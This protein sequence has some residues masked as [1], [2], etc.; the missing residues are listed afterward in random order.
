MSSTETIKITRS[1]NF[2]LL[3]LLNQTFKKKSHKCEEGGAN[4][5]ISFGIYWWT[6]K[7]PKSQNFEKMKKNCWRY[8]HFAHVYQKPQSYEVQ[9]EVRQISFVLLGSFT[10]LLTPK[11]KIWTKC[12]KYQ[13]ILF[14]YTCALE[15]KIM[16]C[17][18]PGI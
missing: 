14:F 9:N 13:E 3:L 15:I 16:W 10:P 2:M 12:E 6:L 4:L 1:F 5:G 17:M 7:N 11:I 18:V 8:H